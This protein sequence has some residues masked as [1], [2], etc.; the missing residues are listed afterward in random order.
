MPASAQEFEFEQLL[1]VVKSDG[2]TLPQAVESVR[3]RTKGRIISAETRTKNGKEVH[4]I[5]VLTKD[6]NVK[7][8]KVQGRSRDNG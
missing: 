6:G 3:A 7:T 5:K 4:H 8:H 1:Q 2:M